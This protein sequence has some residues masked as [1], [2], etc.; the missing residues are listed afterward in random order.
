VLVC[1]EARGEQRTIVLDAMSH[2]MAIVAIRDP[3]VSYLKD[4]QTAHLVS[5]P[6]PEEWATAIEVAV[7][8]RAQAK[9]LGESARSYVAAN[10][11]VS[12]HVATV[13]DVYERVVSG[14]SLP[15]PVSAKSESAGR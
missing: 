8:D 1:P 5:R 14:E 4:G 3:M 12:T 13:L 11:R 7:V 6:A 2:A 15:F 9:Q 10:H